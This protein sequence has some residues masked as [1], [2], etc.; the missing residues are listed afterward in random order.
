MD[1]LQRDMGKFIEADRMLRDMLL[2]IKTLP[3]P[4]KEELKRLRQPYEQHQAFGEHIQKKM[5]A[6]IT[7]IKTEISHIAKS[8]K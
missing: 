4:T 1:E 5:V 8:L 2:S 7:S 3:L 6:S